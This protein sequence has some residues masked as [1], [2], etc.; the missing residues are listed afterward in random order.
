MKLPFCRETAAALTAV[1]RPAGIDEAGGFAWSLD[2]SQPFIATAI[3]AGHTLRKELLP[4]MRISE[5]ERFY[6]ED[7]F[8]D[9][10]IKKCPSAV[11]G[12]DS[13]A[14]YD[15]NRDRD[16]SVP[17]KPEMFWGLKVYEGELPPEM[18]RR[19]IEK[20]EAFYR[21]FGT[22]VTL[23]RE[24]FG[25]CIVYDFHSYNIRR[26]EK[27]GHPSPPVFNVGTEQL[28]RK[29]WAPLIDAWL[30][31]LGDIS[32]SGQKTSVA[33]NDVF[34]GRGGFCRALINGDTDV[35]VLPTEIAKIYMDESTGTP[36]GDVID[37]LTGEIA[38][39]V[40]IHGREC[41]RLMQEKKSR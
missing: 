2:L 21:F 4:F 6:E 34:F 20:Y 7:P 12:L 19:S 33:E 17:L 35:L 41:L 23:I 8:T 28:D 25:F 15:L 30:K 5:G 29:K 18:L 40:E 13:R 10:M 36:F 11:W 37:E 39:A 14:E 32:L 3:H 38:I 22:L 1:N 31:A 9:V 24:R 16:E 26:K 27:E